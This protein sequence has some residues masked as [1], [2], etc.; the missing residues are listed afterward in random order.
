MPITSATRNTALRERGIAVM[1][2]DEGPMACGE[3]GA[4]RLPEPVHVY[5]A[6]CELLGHEQMLLPGP[7]MP[8]LD[9]GWAGGEGEETLDPVRSAGE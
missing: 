9:L 7:D 4:G 2:P 5:N 3:F 6:I 1:E 8:M